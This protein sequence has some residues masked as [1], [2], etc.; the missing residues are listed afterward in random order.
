MCK[1]KQPK[2]INDSRVNL[3]YINELS[4]AFYNEIIKQDSENI[5]SYVVPHTSSRK[6]SEILGLL[7]YFKI[8]YLENGQV[9]KVDLNTFE[10][11]LFNTFTSFI[12]KDYFPRKFTN[13]Y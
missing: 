12:P 3:I 5:K 8:Q 13:T 4:E 2:V 11:D 1:E 6:V 9:P 7:K 10:L